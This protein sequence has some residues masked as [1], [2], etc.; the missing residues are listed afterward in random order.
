MSEIIFP[1]KASIARRK[2]I[3]EEKQPYERIVCTKEECLELFDSNPFKKAMISGKL[4][5]GYLPKLE[6]TLSKH[7][8]AE[9][10]FK[11]WDA[12]GSGYIEVSE[13]GL[14]PRRLDPH[15]LTTAG[16]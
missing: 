15:I 1:I 9:K 8:G 10:L 14:E 4:P 11:S 6:A 13:G 12:D 2:K 16:P 5:E 7:V 3:A